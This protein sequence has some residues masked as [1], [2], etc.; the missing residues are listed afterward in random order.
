M[1]AWQIV[2]IVVLVGALS[3]TVLRLVEYRRIAKELA[4]SI[5]SSHA[6]L[7]NTKKGWYRYPHWR[8]LI[9]T[10][11][12]LLEEKRI[13]EADRASHMERLKATLTN[14]QEAV[15]IVDDEDRVLLTNEAFRTLFPS[16][17]GRFGRMDGQFRYGALVE[18]LRLVREG[19]SQVRREIELTRDGQQVWL[20]ASGSRISGFGEDIGEASLL[21][22]HDIT[23]LR[24]LESIRKEFVANV[25]H[26]LRT[27]LSLIKGYVETLCEPGGEVTEEDRRRFLGIIEKHT[28]RLERLVEDL[29][30]LSRLESG[31][32]R[33]R[34]ENIV[35]ENLIGEIVE[36]YSTNKEDN[37]CTFSTQF[38][39]GES[40]VNADALRIAQVMGNLLENAIKYSGGEVTTIETGTRREDGMVT[41]WVK[42][43]GIGIAEA[44]LPHIFERFYRVDKGRSRESG[45]TGLGLSI[46]KHIVQLHGGEVWAESRPG[47]GTTILFNLPLIDNKGGD[48]VEG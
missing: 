3:W 19:G 2:L 17:E 32:P 35:L 39:S 6:Y 46:V 11:N 44:D 37:R 26:E 29:L 43:N 34:R 5:R 10:I 18:Y 38:D 27:P 15:L 40:T 22:L 23:R 21:L 14:M 8:N 13:F 33:L 41:V 28:V 20:E 36:S 1:S 12:E 9:E 42:D 30:S 31:N 16:I 25:S 7:R 4:A 47:K 48:A 24:G 45:G